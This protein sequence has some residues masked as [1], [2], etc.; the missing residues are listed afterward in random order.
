M[1]NLP[2]SAAAI[3]IAAALALLG[4]R[5]DTDATG[6]PRGF[7]VGVSLR[8]QPGGSCAQMRLPAAVADYPLG[9]GSRDSRCGPAGRNSP[10]PYAAPK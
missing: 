9:P 2:A 1:I 7:D 4:V 6:A 8:F 5:P 10:S 3:A